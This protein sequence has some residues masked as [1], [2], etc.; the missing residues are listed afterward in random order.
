MKQIREQAS[1]RFPLEIHFVHRA[2]DGVVGVLA[3]FVEQGRADPTLRAVLD[4]MPGEAGSTRAVAGRML[5]PRGLL[6]ANGTYYRYEGPLTTPP[7]SE[8]V[9]WAI[10]GSPIQA[11]LRQIKAFEKLYPMNA[12]P[13]QALNRRF[14]LRNQ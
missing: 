1:R 5:N 9:D 7:C 12:R 11:S 14:L 4:N 8:S 3:V 10:M 6:P 2:S 13:L